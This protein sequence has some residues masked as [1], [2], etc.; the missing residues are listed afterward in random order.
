MSRSD[1]LPGPGRFRR[2]PYTSRLGAVPP[3]TRLSRGAPWGSPHMPSLLP[4]RVR[5]S[6]AVVRARSTPA[7]PQRPRGRHPQ[8]SHEATPGFAARY[9]LC[10]CARPSGTRSS[11]NSAL[12]VTRHASLQLPGR[13]AKSQ[14]RTSTS[15]SYGIHGIRTLLPTLTCASSGHRHQRGRHK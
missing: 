14:G 9:G 2:E 7:I 5:T 4:R 13:T 10:G 3:P 11:G 12:P 8:L 6:Q 15:K 1:C